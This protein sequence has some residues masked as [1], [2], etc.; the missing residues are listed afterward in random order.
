MRNSVH[1]GSISKFAAF[2][3]KIKG[4]KEDPIKKLTVELLNFK[5]LL[6]CTQAKVYWVHVWLRLILEKWFFFLQT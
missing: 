1:H 6:S 5:Y 3:N 2:K 4:L